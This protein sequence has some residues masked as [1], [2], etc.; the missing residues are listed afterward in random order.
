MTWVKLDDGFT[1]HRKLELVGPLAGWLHVCALCYCARNLTDGRFPK[2]KA[3][4]LADVPKPAQLAAKLVEV[5]LWEDDGDDYVIHDFGDYNPS[6]AQVEKERKAGADRQRRSRESR[7]LSRRD[8]DRTNG[9]S[10]GQSA[11]VSNGVSARDPVPVPDYLENTGLSVTSSAYGA[12]NDDDD[13]EPPSELLTAAARILG[14]GDH[15][16][17]LSDGVTVRHHPS[18]LQEC[19]RRR[20]EEDPRLADLVRRNPDLT[21]A[22][23]AEL[24]TDASPLGSPADPPPVAGGRPLGL[25]TVAPVTDPDCPDCDGMGVY[26]V[27][28][29]SNTMAECPCKFRSAS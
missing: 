1:E 24:A 17:A 6:R 20:R 14:Q 12:E 5:G 23:I 28:E 22:Q 10:H 19:I 18:H 25:V 26:F 13:R 29:A 7:G 11:G 9:V 8:S 2:S 27:D 16:Q 15:E 4:R 3:L 21:A